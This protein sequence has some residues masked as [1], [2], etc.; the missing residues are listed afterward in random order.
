MVGQSLQCVVGRGSSGDG[1]GDNVGGWGP[2][3]QFPPDSPLLWTRPR[4][5]LHAKQSFKRIHIV[6][7]VRM[8]L[9]TVAIRSDKKAERYSSCQDRSENILFVRDISQHHLDSGRLSPIPLS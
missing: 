7:Q 2:D 4:L 8:V 6:L 3:Y 5:V 9:I 1:G